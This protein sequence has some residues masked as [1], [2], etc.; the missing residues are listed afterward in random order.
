MLFLEALVS[1]VLVFVFIHFRLSTPSRVVALSKPRDLDSVLKH[2]RTSAT[3]EFLCSSL[4]FLFLVGAG[5]R[6]DDVTD[7][8]DLFMLVVLVGLLLSLARLL[9]PAEFLRI[10]GFHPQDP[11]RPMHSK[12]QRPRLPWD[13]PPRSP[14]RGAS[15]STSPGGHSYGS[16]SQR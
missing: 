6:F 15:A 2:R 4:A 13:T 16:R 9:F 5:Y 8:T 12:P 7:L 14:G 1:Y 11:H 10:G 3:Y